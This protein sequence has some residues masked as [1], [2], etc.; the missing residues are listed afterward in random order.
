MEEA[1]YVSYERLRDKMSKACVYSI[2]QFIAHFKIN[3]SNAR[4]IGNRKIGSAIL[5]RHLF[6]LSFWWYNYSDKELKGIQNCVLVA[7]FDV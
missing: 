5:A 7:C 1:V 4:D 2:E 3:R 6:A